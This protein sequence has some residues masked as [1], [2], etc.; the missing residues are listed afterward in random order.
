MLVRVAA[1]FCCYQS[2]GGRHSCFWIVGSANI[3]WVLNL[4]SCVE[5]GLNGQVRTEFSQHESFQRDLLCNLFSIASKFLSLCDQHNTG[6][7]DKKGI[8]R[9]L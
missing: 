8:M 9:Y 4:V 7:L 1:E 3:V 2:D 6:Q 5:L